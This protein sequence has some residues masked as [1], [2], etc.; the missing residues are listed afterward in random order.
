MKNIPNTSGPISVS[1]SPW[2]RW[3]LNLCRAGCEP[4]VGKSRWSRGIDPLGSESHAVRESRTVHQP[5]CA[6]GGAG[7]TRGTDRAPSGQGERVPDASRSHALR[8][9]ARQYLSEIECITSH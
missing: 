6:G 1:F 5:T 3:G 8:G 4:P 7:R 9:C 2:H